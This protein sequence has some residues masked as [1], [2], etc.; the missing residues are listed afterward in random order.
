[1]QLNT[2]MEENHTYVKDGSD[3]TQ[4]TVIVDN[5]RAYSHVINDMHKK[6]SELFT[7]L[8]TVKNNVGSIITLYKNNLEQEIQ[9]M[10]EPFEYVG[11]SWADVPIE[12]SS[13]WVEVT[14][15]PTKRADTFEFSCTSTK[16]SK[17]R[18]WYEIRVMCE[19]V[20]GNQDGA[21]ILLPVVNTEKQFRSLPSG[22]FIYNKSE[23][24]PKLSLTTHSS[25]S[26]GVPFGCRIWNSQDDATVQKYSRYNSSIRRDNGPAPEQFY[27]DK[28]TSTQTNI[29]EDHTRS[30]RHPSRVQKDEYTNKWVGYNVYHTPNFGDSCNLADQLRNTKLDDAYDMYQYSM[31]MAFVSMVH[32]QIKDR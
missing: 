26:F 19:K 3:K 24:I 32:C 15:K 1:V 10:N 13:S 22:M 14:K 8:D 23:R 11:G 18:T 4:K 25:K 5:I 17:D 20:P 7:K 2:L 21:D 28:Y 29:P 16:D 9:R 27:I 6:V 12:N 31:W 30:F